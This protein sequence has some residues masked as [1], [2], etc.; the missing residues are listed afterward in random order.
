MYPTLSEPPR[1]QALRFFR[2][3]FPGY[4]NV[5]PLSNVTLPSFTA[6]VVSEVATA[7]AI[8]FDLALL[9]FLPPLSRQRIV[10]THVSF[11]PMAPLTH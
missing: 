9:G 7:K 5:Q 6:M 2:D 11:C 3:N 4:H 1:F 10:V 8:P